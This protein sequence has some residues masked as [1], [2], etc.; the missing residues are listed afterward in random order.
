[1]TAFLRRVI[2]Y[3]N[4]P[5]D[6]HGKVDEV[7]KRIR[8]SSDEFYARIGALQTDSYHLRAVAD[9]HTQL[10]NEL[11]A[12]EKE[13]LKTLSEIQTGLRKVQVVMQQAQIS[14]EGIQSGAI[15][16]EEGIPIFFGEPQRDFDD[17]SNFS[18]LFEAASSL[19]LLG[20]RD[21]TDT[22]LP[23]TRAPSRARELC[24]RAL[25][26]LGGGN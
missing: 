1:M 11:N 18:R 17:S 20:K 14:L 23:A 12:R 3:L 22:S 25:L 5:A 21:T 10:L 8:Q 4:Y 15:I 13:A 19:I 6:T 16:S 7:L 24:E 9:C 26:R 2:R